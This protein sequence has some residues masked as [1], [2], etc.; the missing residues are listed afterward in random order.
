MILKSFQPGAHLR[1]YIRE[2]V[3][4]D[5]VIDNILIVPV[6]PYPAN[7][8]QCITFYVNG[9]VTSI[10]PI[11]RIKEK[12]PSTVIFG[13]PVAEFTAHTSIFDVRY[14]VSTWCLM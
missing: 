10:D 12:L 1:K 14:P 9:F 11:T 13:Q 4:I 7:P 5:L 6:K 3:V 2:Y 8:E